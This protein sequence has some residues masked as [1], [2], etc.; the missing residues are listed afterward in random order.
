M[1]TE[2]FTETL[3]HIYCFYFYIACHFSMGEIMALHEFQSIVT[4][5]NISLLTIPPCSCSAIHLHEFIPFDR[6]VIR[7][8]PLSLLTSIYPVWVRF[9]KPFFLITYHK[10][11]LSLSHLKQNCSLFTFTLKLLCY[12]YIQF[13]AFSLFLC[14]TISPLPQDS[15]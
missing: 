9:S 15:S 1:C 14:I 13:M 7:W 11:Q 3:Y 5:S 6:F 2:T 12:L 4:L 8:L 10:F